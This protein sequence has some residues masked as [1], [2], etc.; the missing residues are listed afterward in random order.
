MTTARQ[1][2]CLYDGRLSGLG[3]NLSQASLLAHVEEFGADTQTSLAERL[4]LGR[5][6]TGALVDH[7]EERGLVERMPDPD[8]RRVWLV[9]TT[10]TG[11]KLVADINHIDADL[12]RELRSG[13]SRQERQQLASLLVRIQDNLSAGLEA[14]AGS[15]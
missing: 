13:I 12:R 7:L 11:R 2:R 3:L 1:I 8:D 14:A 6:A 10:A 9:A 5:A 15:T 4:G